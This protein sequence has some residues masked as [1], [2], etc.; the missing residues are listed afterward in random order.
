MFPDFS[1]I[2][3]T[4]ETFISDVHAYFKLHFQSQKDLHAKIDSMI[5]RSESLDKQLSGFLAHIAAIPNLPP[6]ISELVTKFKGDE[7]VR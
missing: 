3:N 6:E 5:A 4:I 7:N 2:T 1:K